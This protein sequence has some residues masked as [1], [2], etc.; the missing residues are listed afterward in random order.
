MHA[1]VARHRPTEVDAINGALVRE[2]AR[3]GLAAPLNAAMTVVVSALHPVE[4]DAAGS[5]TN[6]T[7]PRSGRVVLGA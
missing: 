2:A 4:G 7:E 3:H 1:D 5:A 6:D